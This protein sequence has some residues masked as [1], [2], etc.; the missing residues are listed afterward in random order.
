MKM[1]FSA[2]RSCAQ[3]LGQVATG[4]PLGH[5]D[6]G[7]QQRDFLRVAA[8][9]LQRFPRSGRLRKSCS[10]DSPAPAG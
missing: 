9:D 1:T 5:D 2:G 10:R 8:P 7:E 4:D 3:L 6:V